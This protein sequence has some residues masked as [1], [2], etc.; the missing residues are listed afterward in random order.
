M[1]RLA[2]M[3][4]KLEAGRHP[5]IV[6]LSVNALQKD[7]TD[8]NALN[9][10]IALRT[11]CSV[12]NKEAFPEGVLKAIQKGSVDSSVYVRKC[13]AACILSY[14][15]SNKLG[16]ESEVEETVTI[17]ERL[18]GDYEMT[19]VSVAMMAVWTLFSRSEC[20]MDV[21]HAHFERLVALLPSMDWVG[22]YFG[23]QVFQEYSVRNFRE[24]SDNAY[25]KTFIGT[26]KKLISSSRSPPVV[27]RGISVL[28]CIL[29]DTEIESVVLAKHFLSMP[30]SMIPY[31][32]ELNALGIS[33]KR[34]KPFLINTSTDSDDV[35]LMKLKL[36]L[37]SLTE[38]NC[39][40]LLSELFRYVFCSFS[41][42]FITEC[43]NGIL[44]IGTRFIKFQGKALSA[45][46]RCVGSG[47]PEICN[48][49]VQA[50][51]RLMHSATGSGSVKC[52]DAI[53]A[54]ICYN[55]GNMIGTISE[56]RAKASAL[57]LVQVCHQSAPEVAPKVLRTLAK[58]LANEDSIVKLELASL[59]VIVLK[60]NKL[61]TTLVEYILAVSARDNLVGDIVAVVSAPFRQSV[62]LRPSKAFCREEPALNPSSAFRLNGPKR[63]ENDTP[64]SLRCPFKVKESNA[65]QESCGNKMSSQSVTV[66]TTVP[67]SIQTLE[68]L[69]FFFT[70][71]P[72]PT[73][74][75]DDHSKLLV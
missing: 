70:E 62:D 20:I 1:K 75:R 31:F 11:I 53:K 58:T 51:S 38:K 21:L 24:K 71:V 57:W 3:C 69:D 44:L 46:I 34:I 15:A 55:L 41:K 37:N 48:A 50:L 32:L 52:D 33:V 73:R 26:I 30:P 7:M 19:V 43:I 56:P 66:P 28:N 12:P 45:L 18:L 9:R 67:P 68:D 10:G 61:E 47:N 59:A 27:F 16:E 63:P 72:Q 42:S 36:L 2:H 64:D 23:L 14:I 25:L 4:L 39:E 13:A 6:L 74:N 54:K 29:G 35:Q 22:Q 60:E 8:M 65:S 40:F 17:V 5:E 49:A